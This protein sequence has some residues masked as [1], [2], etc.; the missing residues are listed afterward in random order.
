[1]PSIYQPVLASGHSATNIRINKKFLPRL[2]IR[3][4]IQQI[5]RAA[6]TQLRPEIEMTGILSPTAYTTISG[7]IKIKRNHEMSWLSSSW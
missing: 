2:L 4:N 3:K 6:K 5:L 7:E 1:M